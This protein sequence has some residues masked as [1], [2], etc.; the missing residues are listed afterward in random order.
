MAV[1][2]VASASWYAAASVLMA[3]YQSDQLHDR[4]IA[5]IERVRAA[6]RQADTASARSS[7]L[8]TAV[9]HHY[10]AGRYELGDELIHAVEAE[11]GPEDE[12][13]PGISA[14]LLEA[15][16]YRAGARAEQ[17]KCLE[18][19]AG[20]ASAFARDG[21]LRNA[22][23]TSSAL[24]YTWLQLG[25]YEQAVDSLEGTLR[26]AER[27]GLAAI[28]PVVR[29]NLGLAAA[30]AGDVARGE[31]EQRRALD[32]LHLQADVRMAAISR[33]Y[34]AQILMLR[35]DL[36]GAEREVAP[37][38][39]ALRTSPPALALALATIAQLRLRRGDRAGA[40]GP[41]EEAQDIL[42]S[43][44]GLDEGEALVRLSYAQAL[45][46]AGREAEARAATEV[47]RARVVELADQLALPMLRRAF[48]ERVPENA[49][50][51][52]L[53]LELID[54]TMP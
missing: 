9:Q 24:G 25:A 12:R 43:L 31:K 22:C 45:F 32:A 4:E 42:A 29:Q 2:P 1:L 10:L 5:L 18:L 47:A 51:L 39:E 41:A 50:I 21:D 53:A 34:L 11:V 27:L 8:C 36:D 44:G 13:A 28:V 35:Q 15:H 49:A 48:L 52:R 33:V 14:R 17:G 37:A 30:L 54:R 7:A 6:P 46:A 3:A 16:A 19:L 40:L 23:R 20:A 26:E 38:V